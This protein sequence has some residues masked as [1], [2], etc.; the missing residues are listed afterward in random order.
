MFPT[1][2]FVVMEKYSCLLLAYCLLLHVQSKIMDLS[3]TWLH[4]WKKMMP[5]WNWHVWERLQVFMP[6]NFKLNTHTLLSRWMC[7]RTAWYWCDAWIFAPVSSFSQS[8]SFS[9]WKQWMVCHPPVII[10]ISS[11]SFSFGEVYFI[12][13]VYVRHIYRIPPGVDVW[14]TGPLDV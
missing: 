5:F 7:E 9:G 4:C 3:K 10:W 6:P 8:L 2:F 12:I 1:S 14:A 13:M 11:G